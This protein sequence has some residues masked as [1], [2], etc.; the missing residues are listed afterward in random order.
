MPAV[1]SLSL[2]FVLNKLL[3]ETLS[4]NSFPTHTQHACVGVGN[5]SAAGRAK[6]LPSKVAGQS[7]KPKAKKI[8]GANYGIYMAVKHFANQ[9]VRVEK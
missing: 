3:S 2:L 6:S 4:E 9:M 8:K 7:I 5:G 1:P